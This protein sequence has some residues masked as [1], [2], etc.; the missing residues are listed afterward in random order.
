MFANFLNIHVCI[1]HDFGGMNISF[2][3]YIRVNV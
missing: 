2:I 3:S 1:Y